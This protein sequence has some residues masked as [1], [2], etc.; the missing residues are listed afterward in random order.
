[1]IYVIVDEMAG[2]VYGPFSTSKEAWKHLDKY[3]PT[4]AEDA[5]YVTRMKSPTT[6]PG[7]LRR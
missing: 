4:D 5:V 2:E 6:I 3:F 7:V 1:M